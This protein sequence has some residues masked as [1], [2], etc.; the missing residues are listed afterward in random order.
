MSI[1]TTVVS[2]KT[3]ICLYGGPG[4]GKSTTAAHIFAKLKQAGH[5]AELVAEYVKEWAWEGRHVLNG[6]QYYFLAKQ[7]RRERIRYKDTDVIVTDSPIWLSAVYERKHEE[8][9]HIS[10]AF[11]DKHVQLAKSMGVEHKHVFLDRVKP[12]NPNGRWQTEDEA[13]ELDGDILAYLQELGLGY[14]RVKADNKAADIILEHFAFIPPKITFIP[15]IN[16]PP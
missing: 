14:L 1:G 2:N 6:D 10:Q 5:N 16:T 8:P 12:F 3:V 15:P 4:T 11:I 9:P 7:S 13:K